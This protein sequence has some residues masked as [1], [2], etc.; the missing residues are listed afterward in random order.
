MSNDPTVNANKKDNLRLI[1]S[2]AMLLFCAVMVAVIVIM[3]T[4]DRPRR[5]DSALAEC[6]ANNYSQ[7][8]YDGDTLYFVGYMG[9]TSR[10]CIY[11]QDA[12]GERTRLLQDDALRRF[13]L[14]GDRILYLCARDGGYEL[15][16]M[17][18]SGG[19]SRQLAVLPEKENAAVTEF[20]LRGDTLYYLYDGVLSA[21][22]T[23]SGT[24][25]T[26]ASGAASF[27]LAGNDVYYS[28]DA[29]I[30][31]LKKGTGTPEFFGG[32]PRAMGLALSGDRLYYRTGEGIFYVGTKKD[33][34]EMIVALDTRVTSF[35][36]RDGTVYY[37]RAVSGAEQAELAASMAAAQGI[38]EAEALELLTG[39][40]H[41]FRVNG[42]G[43]TP[44]SVGGKYVAAFAMSPEKIYCKAFLY[45]RV[46]YEYVE[47]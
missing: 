43:G 37:I 32:A 41:L 44:T 17:P 22:D 26:L 30:Q 25:S 7:F 45:S 31:L 34:S 4:R 15:C 38:T 18:V 27:M 33:R 5:D 46:F 3:A 29:G 23:S 14:C 10:M 19:G 35:C 36:V 47:D 40:G 2:A 9:E 21:M 24:V 11:A 28:T 16:T 1:G 12:S 20:D 39:V 42:S 8:A 13:R 6:N